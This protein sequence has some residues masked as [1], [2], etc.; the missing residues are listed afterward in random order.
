MYV[1]VYVCMYVCIY[2]CMCV[3]KYNYVTP[4]ALKRLS[5]IIPRS[6]MSEDLISPPFS[7][8]FGPGAHQ[9]LSGASHELFR[10]I[11]GPKGY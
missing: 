8:I 10:G 11:P 1:R 4:D 2:V 7:S 9:G 6:F 3:C 5:C